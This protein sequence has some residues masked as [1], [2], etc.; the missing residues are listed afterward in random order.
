MLNHVKFKDI[1]IRD[2]SNPYLNF[3]VHHHKFETLL[4]GCSR[5]ADMY[6]TKESSRI[7]FQVEQAGQILLDPSGKKVLV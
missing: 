2:P 7:R 3:I 4:Q 1:L 6:R 5:V